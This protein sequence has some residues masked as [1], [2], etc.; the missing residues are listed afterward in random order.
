MARVAIATATYRAEGIV[1][2]KNGFGLPIKEVYNIQIEIHK[3]RGQ[4]FC[5]YLQVGN[6]MLID[7]R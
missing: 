5:R 6:E 2:M 3:H 4:P 7:R 1:E